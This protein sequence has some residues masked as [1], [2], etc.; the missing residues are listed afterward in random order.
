MNGPL[1]NIQKKIHQI[2]SDDPAKYILKNPRLWPRW[3]L[4]LYSQK[5]NEQT[6]SLR[7][8]DSGSG[9]PPYLKKNLDSGSDVCSKI[10]YQIPQFSP[11]KSVTQDSTT[12]NIQ[13]NKL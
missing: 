9:S 2:Y 13:K 5:I 12:K 7:Y 8:H 11:H 4:K 3:A 1:R 6:L 10:F